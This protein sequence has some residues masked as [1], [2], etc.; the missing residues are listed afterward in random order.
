MAVPYLRVIVCS[1]NMLRLCHPPLSV[2]V[3]G[4]RTF[5]PKHVK[6]TLSAVAARKRKYGDTGPHPRSSFVE[7]NYPAELHAFSAR[8]GE[9]VDE[10]AVRRALTERSFVLQRRLERERLGLPDPEAESTEDNSALAVR[11][12]ELM[13][14]YVAGWLRAALPRV[15][16]EGVQAV[17]SYLTSRSQL[18]D[19]ASGIGLRDIVLSEEYPPSEEALVRCLCAWLAALANSA[20]EQRAH[21]FVR[22]FVIAR[23]AAADI[24][25]AWE[26]EEPL[27]V[28]GDTLRRCGRGPPESRL[29][30]SAGPS[31][32]LAAYL[33]GVYSDRQLM[34]SAP[35]ES[36]DEASELAARDAL[37]RLMGVT[38][39]SAAL[40]LR[41]ERKPAHAPAAA[42]ADW[43]PL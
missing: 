9:T 18:H 17:T 14:S 37:N 27:S 16:E 29:L 38:E 7:W 8:L 43:R 6:A 24:N 31:S 42:L 36:M 15:P 23:L 30:R 41:A 13:T 33:V 22:D 2:L 40:D 21:L 39:A 4:K 35:G 1:Q 3:T 5:L 32:L 25:T 19:L 12:R 26:I 11:G 10:A 34:G 20:G 28:L